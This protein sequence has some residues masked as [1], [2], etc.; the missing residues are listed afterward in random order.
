MEEKMCNDV[1]TPGGGGHNKFW[2]GIGALFAVCIALLVFAVI[3]YVMSYILI[4]HFPFLGIVPLGFLDICK[5][6]VLFQTANYLV[7]RL[8]EKQ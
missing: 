6:G 8:W 4:W 5:Y 1:A 2:M 7:S 3:V